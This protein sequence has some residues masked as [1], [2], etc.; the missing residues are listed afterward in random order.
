VKRALLL[1]LAAG[2]KREEAALPPPDPN[3]SMLTL[4][5]REPTMPDAP[6][7][8][9]FTQRCLI[10]HSARYVLNQ[11]KLPRKNWSAV[12][13]KMKTAYGAPLDD[14]ASAQIVDYVVKVNGAE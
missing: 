5:A 1:L 2:C 7:K 4:D 3:V 13:A 8:E 12:V 9:A 6:G 10:C 14:A 11:P